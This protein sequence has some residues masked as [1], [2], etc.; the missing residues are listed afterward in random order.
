MKRIVF[1][2]MLIAAVVLIEFTSFAWPIERIIVAL[3]LPLKKTAGATQPETDSSQNARAQVTENLF[4]R[5]NEELRKILAFKKRTYRIMLGADIIGYSTDPSR[6][7]LI[8]NIGSDDGVQNGAPVIA[9]DGV[10]IGR[11]HTANVHNS[12]IMPLSDPRSKILA[13]ISRKDGSIYAIAEGRFNV[14]VDMTYIPVTEDVQQGDIVVTSGLQDGVAAGFIIGTI[15]EVRKKP[16][17]LFQTAIMAVP[18]P[19]EPPP[20]VSIIVEKTNNP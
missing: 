7:Y 1:F 17:D 11:V 8:A 18:Y 14:G 19:K 6:A 9:G 16:E 10:L 20:V 2:G 12:I 13:L 15:Q 4:A 5:E 3:S